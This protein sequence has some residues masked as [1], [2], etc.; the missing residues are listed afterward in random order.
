M[1]R[2]EIINRLLENHQKFTAY[3]SLLNEPDFDFSLQNKK[4]TAG[5]QAEH[6]NRSISPLNLALRLPKWLIKVLFGKA[7]RP[8]KNYEELVKKYLKKLADGG[9]A[10]GRF[11]PKKTEAIHKKH[12]V[13]KIENSVFKLCKILNTYSEEEMDK[14]VLPH[15]LLGKLTLREMMYF[16]AYHVEH[17]YET[18]IRNLGANNVVKINE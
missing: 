10:A 18:T 9:R 16:T 14:M 2:Q 4:W 7:N 8:S 12:L 3:I 11:I 13:N 1:T 6:I 17:H 15:P 5:Q